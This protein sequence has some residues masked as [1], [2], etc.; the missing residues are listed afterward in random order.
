[1]RAA[2]ESNSE[3][4][5]LL[6]DDTAFQPGLAAALKKLLGNSTGGEKR[7]I[8][9]WSSAEF[10]FGYSGVLLHSTDLPVFERLHSVLFDEKPCDLLNFKA[11]IKTGK[12]QSVKSPKKFANKKNSY[13]H[14]LGNVSTLQ[15]KNTP[16]WRR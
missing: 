14:H 10:G 15:E 4:V 13:F 6:E 8:P 3:F 12:T 9:L 16:V 7:E 1:M 11:F 2:S 5:M